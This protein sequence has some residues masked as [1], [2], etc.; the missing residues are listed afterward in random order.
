MDGYLTSCCRFTG[1]D[2]T[3]NDDV[4][5]DLLFTIEIMVLA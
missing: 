4:D 3:D 5:M 2:V 1:V